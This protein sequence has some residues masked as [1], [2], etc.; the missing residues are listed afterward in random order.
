MRQA[1]DPGNVARRWWPL[2][3]SDH[4]NLYLGSGRCGACLDPFGLMHNGF[5]D[6]QRQ[7]QGHTALMHADHWHR[8][9]Y[10]LDYWLPLARLVWADEPPGPPADYRQR[11]CL[12]DAVL[13][14]E[15]AWPRLHLRWKARCHPERRDLMAFHLHYE[16][17]MPDLLLAPQTHVRTHYDQELAGH[18]HTIELEP[19]QGWWL[20]RLSV[21]TADSVVAL[22]VVSTEGTAELKPGDEGLRL[23]FPDPRGRH[24]LLLGAAAFA[25]R[26]MLAAEMHSIRVPEQFAAEARQA[27]HRRWG[28]ARL[29]L[30]VPQY[31]ALWARSLYYVLASYAPDVRSPAAPMGW[32]GNGWPFHFP[33]DVSYIH[34]ALL[35]LGHFDIARAWVEFYRERLESMQAYTRRIYGADGAMWAWEFPIGPD[36]Q[37]L[38][39][40]FPN[41]C[42]FE[43]HNAAYPARMARD[44]ARYLH[45]PKWTEEVAWPVI[46][47]SARFFASILHRQDDGSWGIA[48]QPSFGQDEMGGHNATN[49]LCA[50]FSAQ[51]TLQAALHTARRLGHDEPDF[52]RWRQVLDDGLAFPA[53]RDPDTG[54]LATC[55]GE[56]G[57]RQLG[58]QKHPVQL[59]PL[60]FLPLGRPDKHVVRAYNRRYDLCTGAREGRF[61]GWTLAAFWLAASHMGDPEGLAHDLG[62]A[63][64]ARIVDPQ[65]LQIYEASAATHAPYYVTSHGLYLQALADALVSDYFADTRIGAACPEEWEE[66]AF[67]SLHTAEGS[68]ISGR[69]HEGRWHTETRIRQ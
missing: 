48:L 23:R 5:R 37:L 54:I 40:G 4:L 67:Q 36:S 9:V 51:Y 20:C 68:V 1:L 21:G 56:P 59:N 32:T 52:H 57:T 33:Q 43:I 46:R 55:Q 50:L 28:N 2:R 14:T 31:Q 42:Q 66:L 60:T 8:G 6:A 69:K 22:R 24:L 44:T 7:S 19:G 65:W 61:H 27:W 26:D 18:A 49:Y 62:Q 45:E 16:G 47:E 34:P 53:L 13:A 35:R 38:D 63:Q 39:D 41:W 10:G 29:H 11:L 3:M 15:L 25:R 12:H 30:P 17:E 58:R 64:P